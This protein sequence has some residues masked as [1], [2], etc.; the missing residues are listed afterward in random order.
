MRK[1]TNKQAWN[2]A[3]GI[4]QTEGRK[5]SGFMMDLIGR[6]K[7]GEI[8]TENIGHMLIEYGSRQPH[9]ECIKLSFGCLDPLIIH[10][11]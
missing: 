2:F 3:I 4:V 1:L 10:H 9:F 5:P 8:T 7:R 6:E 11:K